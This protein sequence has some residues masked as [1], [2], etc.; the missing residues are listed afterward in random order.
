MLRDSPRCW[1]RNRPAEPEIQGNAEQTQDHP[2]Q[3][4]KQEYSRNDKYNEG[5]DE[6]D[7]CEK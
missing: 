2:A 3:R 6:K 5:D 7:D 1:N 4:A